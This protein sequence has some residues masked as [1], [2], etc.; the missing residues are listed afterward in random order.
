MP[1]AF[2]S[3]SRNSGTPVVSPRHVDHVSWLEVEHNPE[4]RGNLWRQRLSRGISRP[5][6]EGCP[7]RVSRARGTA[8]VLILVHG[9]QKV[10]HAWQGV[11]TGPRRCLFVGQSMEKRRGVNVASVPTFEKSNFQ[12]KKKCRGKCSF[13]FFGSVLNLRFV[14]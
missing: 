14:V 1:C 9:L 11:L 4:F 2:F 7:S 5:R 3:L 10:T 6:A 13:F 8:K 12:K